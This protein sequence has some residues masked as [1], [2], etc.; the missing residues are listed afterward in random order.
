[1][2]V[3]PRAGFLAFASQRLSC[4]I[5]QA[6]FLLVRKPHTLFFMQPGGKLEDGETALDTLARELNEEPGCTLLGTLSKP[7]FF[8]SRVRVT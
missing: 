1:M 5:T 8:M 6:V 4:W 3:F 7:H 2:T